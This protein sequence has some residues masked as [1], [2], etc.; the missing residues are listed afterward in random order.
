MKG[1]APPL[2]RLYDLGDL[3]QAGAHIAVALAGDELAALARWV[4]VE[5]LEN[6]KAEIE[7]RK[8]SPTRYSYEAELTAD[9]VQSC[10]VTLDPVRS[11][12]ER[13]LSRQLVLS[14][15][16]YR[17]G[18]KGDDW[19][20]APAEDDAPEEIASL[21]YDLAAP[22]LEELVL[23]IDPYPRAAGVAFAPPPGADLT[24]ELPESPFA[25]LK[26]LKNQP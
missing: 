14:P 9:V 22:L 16:A 25:V 8:L 23:A 18:Q 2:E 4:G 19:P 1:E 11:H 3:S 12:I 26:R 6:F 10:V 20:I 13:H 17:R 7:L 21:R 5:A 15:S 24:S